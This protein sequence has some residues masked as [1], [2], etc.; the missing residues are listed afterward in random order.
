MSDMNVKFSYPRNDEY[1]YE[2][3]LERI[4]LDEERKNDIRSGNGFIISESQSIKKEIKNPNGIFSSKYGQTLQDINPFAD[5]YKCECGNLKSRINHGLIC[6]LCNTRVRYVDDN[7]GYFGWICLKDP[8]YIIHPN[9]YKSLEFFIGATKLNNILKP[10]DEKDQDGFDVE[11]DRVKGDLFEGLGIIDF[12]LK[13]KEIMNYY[14]AKSPDKKEYYD[15]IMS[16]Y[17]KIFIQSIPVYTTHLRPFR[18]ENGSFYYEGTNAIYV[19]LVR[20]AV[21]INKDN[22]QMNRKKKPKNQ[23]LYDMQIKLNDLYKELEKTISG[24]KGSIRSLFGGRY[25]FSARSVIVPDP[26][27]RIDEVTLSYKALVELLQQ[28]IV[29]ILQKSYNISYADAYKIWYKSQIKI[30]PRVWNIIECIIKDSERG[31]PVLINRNPTIGYGGILQVYVIGINKS[32]TMGIAL[33]T[34]A[35]LGADFDGDTLNVLYIVNKDFYRAASKTLNPRNAMMIS[36]NDG[37]L[38]KGV[39]PQRDTLI[40]STGLLY[41]SRYN[42]SAEQLEKIKQLKG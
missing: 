28:T 30:N 2:S 5:R 4:N 1:E 32:Y 26:K 33:G 39:L 9:L 13:F 6:P 17:N 27:L 24:K 37:Y 31:I 8:Y 18:I 40:N 25:N 20:L 19:I 36:K 15:D 7:F 14:L 35:G 42:Y 41:L 38:N 16:N 11:P 23:L 3:R 29:N 34:L 22:L 12:R 10:I 21:A